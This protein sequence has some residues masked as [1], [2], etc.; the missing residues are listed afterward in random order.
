MGDNITRP[1]CIVLQVVG[2]KVGLGEVIN[3]LTI[4]MISMTRQEHNLLLP[5]AIL[6]VVI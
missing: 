4:N 2:Q 6:K 5:F 3:Y 1:A